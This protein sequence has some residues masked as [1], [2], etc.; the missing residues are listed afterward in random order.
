MYTPPEQKLVISVVS[1][2]A[3]TWSSRAILN[4]EEVL[5]GMQQRYPSAEISLLHFESFPSKSE[6]IL[7]VRRT[8][9]LIGAHGAGK[10]CQRSTC[11]SQ[12]V[13]CI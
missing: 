11:S 2:K 7:A 1:R 3:N 9:V 6:S 13:A 8:H 10:H 5:E 4:E 12:A